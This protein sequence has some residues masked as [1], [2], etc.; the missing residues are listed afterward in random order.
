MNKIIEQVE[1]ENP[2]LSARGME[3]YPDNVVK[4]EK[5]SI[6]YPHS[7]EATFKWIKNNCIPRKSINKDFSSYWLKHVCERNMGHYIPNGCFI[8]A[9][10]ANGYE[11][12]NNCGFGYV[13]ACFNMSSKGLDKLNTGKGGP[14]FDR[15]E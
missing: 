8:A 13:N 9:A 1:Q 7:F 12:Q 5:V 11:Y 2:C 6:A 3:D 15:Y 4:N 14:C 10:L